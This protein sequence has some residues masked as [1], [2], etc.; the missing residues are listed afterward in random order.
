MILLPTVPAFFRAADLDEALPFDA[1]PV[2]LRMPAD[3]L[4][5]LL[6]A[7]PDGFAAIAE[8][9]GLAHGHEP[10]FSVDLDP[11]RIRSMLSK[12]GISVDLGFNDVALSGA[13]GTWYRQ[14]NDAVEEF[15]AID[16]ARAGGP[17]RGA[18]PLSG[19]RGRGRRE[20]HLPC[21][22]HARRVVEAAGDRGRNGRDTEGRVPW[23]CL[24]FN[25]LI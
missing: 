9:A 19:R 10:P 1:A 24:S 8:R 16:L 5:A 3:E 14:M 4:R 11:G 6:S 7:A 17:R 2:L 13:L 22:G 21:A 25:Y 15:W 23:R 18:D 20:A 12:V